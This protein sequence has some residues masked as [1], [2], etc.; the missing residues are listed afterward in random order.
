[1]TSSNFKR[2][3]IPAALVVGGVTVGSFLAPIG[4]AAAQD[5]DS[6][7]SIDSTDQPDSENSEN[8]ENHEHRGH[9]WRR[10]A[11]GRGTGAKVEVLTETLGLT[12]EELRQ[13]FADGKSLADLAA[14]QGVSIDEL[15]SAMVAAANAAIDDAVE[16]G[17]LTAEEAD[18]KRA[19]VEE[20]VDEVIERSPEDFPGLRA[21]MKH[22]RQHHRFARLAASLEEL[23]E[24]LDLSAEEIRAGLADGQTLGELAEGQGI[25]AEELADYLVAGM[26]AR[27]DEAVADEKIDA[28]RADEIKESLDEKV[29]RLIESDHPGRHARRGLHRGHHGDEAP[30]GSEPS[31][32]DSSI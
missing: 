6:D 19:E 25:S 4:L 24:F 3:G 21:R 16:A 22:H 8:G 23:G 14:E 2:F 9:H 5:D 30:A 26:E 12:A 28:E 15:R 10:G 31:V 27:L 1:M 20:R 32:E 29:D 7:D 18:E 13:G 11:L 17:R